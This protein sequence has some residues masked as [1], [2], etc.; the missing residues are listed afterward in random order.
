MHAALTTSV[1]EASEGAGLHKILTERGVPS[2]P[3]RQA[4]KRG[5]G[6]RRKSELI[7][8]VKVS[9][10]LQAWPTRI[11]SKQISVIPRTHLSAIEQAPSTAMMVTEGRWHKASKFPPKR[12]LNV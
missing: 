1:D 2:S 12:A 11:A 4:D 5:E 9:R 7:W 10:S 6:G 3:A 8:L